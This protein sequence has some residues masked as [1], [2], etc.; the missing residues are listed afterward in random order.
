MAGNVDKEIDFGDLDFGLDDFKTRKRI[1]LED[2]PKL[3][4]FLEARKKSRLRGQ[5]KTETNFWVC[6]VF[7]SW[8]QKQEFLRQIEDLPTKYG[9]Y[10]DGEAFAE[11]VGIKVSPNKEKK[12]VSRVFFELAQRTL[13]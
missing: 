6:L 10:V 3:K 11:R 1:L 13:K 4:A 5:D 2:D 12:H 9:M 7:Q 8:D